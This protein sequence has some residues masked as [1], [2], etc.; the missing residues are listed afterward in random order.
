MVMPHQTFLRLSRRVAVVAGLALLAGCTVQPLYQQASPGQVGTAEILRSVA[1]ADVDDRVAQQ[2]RNQLVFLL[3][4]GG[5]S[6]NPARY[7]AT[8]AVTPRVQAVFATT[9]PDGSTQVT[10]SR[11]ILSGTVTLTDIAE[12]TEIASATRIATASYDETRQEFANLRARRDAE[13]RAA[14]ALAEQFRIVIAAALA[15][16]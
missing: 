8:I 6:V 2:V 14:A 3:Y 7:S 11:V 16:R 5:N 1:I 12:G 10:A 15:R 4:Q 9:A 13:D